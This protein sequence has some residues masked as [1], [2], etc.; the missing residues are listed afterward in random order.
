[1]LSLDTVV[2]QGYLARVPGRPNIRVTRPTDLFLEPKGTVLQALN[3]LRGAR[4]ASLFRRMPTGP[5]AFWGM[6]GYGPASG[7]ALKRPCAV[8]AHL[9]GRVTNTI[10]RESAE[11]ISMTAPMADSRLFYE[12]S[13][14]HKKSRR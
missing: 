11:L 5:K 13:N 1:M 14:M 12:V 7:P 6:L 8:L 4:E 2:S 9:V 3:L 10:S